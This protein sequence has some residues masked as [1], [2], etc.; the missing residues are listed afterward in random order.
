MEREIGE[1]FKYKGVTLEV[2]KA[3]KS[4][5]LYPCCDCYF[6]TTGRCYKSMY[7]T[8]KCGHRDDKREVYFK[9]VKNENQ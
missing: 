7:I 1:K 3:H 6:L 2:V 9:E 4:H 5:P 8:G